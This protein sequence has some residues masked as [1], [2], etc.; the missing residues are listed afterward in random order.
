M[1]I[2]KVR[3]AVVI[4]LGGT[5]QWVLTYL[6]KELLE[7]NGGEMPSNV[8]LLSFDTMSEAD[9]HTSGV[10]GNSLE[11]DVAIGNVKLI[12]GE[13]FIPLS[14]NYKD[15]GREIGQDKHKHLG[16][17]FDAPFYRDKAMGNL[18][19]LGTGAGQVRQ[20][21]RL[22]FFMKVDKEIWPR[23]SK[24]YTEV[25]KQISEGKELEVLIVASFAGGTGAGMFIDMGVIARALSH[26]VND[27]LIIRGFFVLPRAFGVEGK[28]GN[29]ENHMK[30]RSFAAWRE[31]NRFV[32]MGA[33]FG[34][35]SITYQPDSPNLNIQNIEERPFDICYILD[36]KRGNYS[37]EADDPRFGVF[38][39]IA[40][41]ASAIL[42]PE[43]GWKYTSY[44]TANL[45]AAM[46]TDKTLPRYSTFGTYSFKS[47][48]YYGVQQRGLEYG[49]KLLENWLVFR[50]D[51]ENKP[52]GLSKI[53]NPEFEGSAGSNQALNFIRSSVKMKDKESE[54]SAGSGLSTPQSIENTNLFAEI[55][56][57]YQ[58]QSMN[59]RVTVE[60]DAEGEYVELFKGEIEPGSFLSMMISLPEDAGV[61]DFQRDVESE[62]AF[63]IWDAAPP[64][65]DRGTDPEVDADRII[66]DVNKYRREHFG[67]SEIGGSKYLGS[68]GNLLTSA[69]EFQVDRF[70]LLLTQWTKNTLNGF[71]EDPVRG[72][73]GKLGFADDFYRELIKIFDYFV[74]YM[75]KVR[76]TRDELQINQIYKETEENT[77]MGMVES[78]S[79]RLPIVGTPAPRA[80]KT[81]EEYLVSVEDRNNAMRY[82]M[83]IESLIDTAEGVRQIAVEAQTESNNW[84]KALVTG[85]VIQGISGIYETLEQE[86]GNSRSIYD[87]DKKAQKTQEVLD[88]LGFEENQIDIDQELRRIEWEVKGSE[89]FK[90]V[91][92]L[93]VPEMKKVD[94]EEVWTDKEMS[95]NSNLTQHS[96]DD[97]LIVFRQLGQIQFRNLPDQN[98]VIKLLMEDTRFEKDPEKLALHL[99]DRAEPLFDPRDGQ[100]VTSYKEYMISRL[101][102]QGQ[103]EEVNDY[104]ETMKQK[105]ERQRNQDVEFANSPDKHRFTAVHS[106]ENIP[107]DHFSMWEDLKQAYIDHIQSDIGTENASRL[108]IFPAEC[109][110]SK[111]EKQLSKVLD[112]PYRTFHP[113]VVTLLENDRNAKLFFRCWSL[114]FI[115]ETDNDLGFKGYNLTTP[116]GEIRLVMPQEK[117]PTIFDVMHSF[118]NRGRDAAGVQK[119]IIYEDVKREI[120]KKENSLRTEGKLA[121]LYNDEIQKGIVAQVRAEGEE[122]LQQAKLES[123]GE[124]SDAEGMYWHPGQE[125]LDLADIAEMIYLE[126]LE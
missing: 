88:I 52:V 18:W 3:P 20:F 110:A 105:M 82:D 115:T 99:L 9:V 12:T 113:R 94:D 103:G 98:K 79:Q 55:A 85:D 65:K 126:V 63:T 64:S 117:E 21:G 112:K 53:A 25:K 70:R 33:D 122:H 29:M 14:G 24:A 48:I 76:E 73:R 58:S 34:M 37:L 5:G 15:I 123:P 66:E 46:V 39:S 124:I 71:T 22:G 102:Y 81:Q 96:Q 97:N 67:Q 104:I 44:V 50:R 54:E 69:K 8:K 61:E 59:D 35:K 68:F 95:L 78:A 118:T 84:I 121:D 109:N 107:C 41:F 31:L 116:A 4:G 111:Y 11:E 40:D 13:E 106:I 60:R 10:G 49:M 16:S 27:S 43:A 57:I 17:W 26:L 42:D 56:K 89:G 7:I 101:N 47:P 38:P 23:V 108:H 45:N 51:D 114:G 120:L 93:M 91:C 6:K 36:S 83:L 86:L 100:S 119:Y 28:L 74:E 1:A 30:A 2:D 72:K 32:T 19:D 80:H 62:L 90:L 87:Y 92:N 75:N 125:L 77:R